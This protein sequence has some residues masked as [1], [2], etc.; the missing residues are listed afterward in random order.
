MEQT[1][2]AG[3]SAES[4]WGMHAA[5]FGDDL[6]PTFHSAARSSAPRF[7]SAWEAADE[8]LEALPYSSR[9]AM[10]NNLGD[11]RY[12]WPLWLSDVPKRLSG[13]AAGLGTWFD[14]DDNR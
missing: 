6:T 12:L 10:F 9:G 5:R 11:R 4:S 7:F 8:A 13:L 1:Q 3:S 2:R 14:S